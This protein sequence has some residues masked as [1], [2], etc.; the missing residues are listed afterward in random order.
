MGQVGQVAPSEVSLDA[1]EH[2]AIAETTNDVT[3]SD[4][5]GTVVAGDATEDASHPEAATYGVHQ[6]SSGDAEPTVVM[7]EVLT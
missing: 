1:V 7:S 4:R 2:V 5:V 6:V 3:N